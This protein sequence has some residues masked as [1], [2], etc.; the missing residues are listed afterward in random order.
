VSADLNAPVADAIA[1][2]RAS[3]R[4][5]RVDHEPDGQGGAFVR[6]H[7]LEIGRAFNPGTSWIGFQITFQFPFADIYPHYLRSDLTSADGKV[8][9]P[10]LHVNNSFALPS[11][12][13]PAVMLSRRS[14]HRDPE[15]ET[16]AVKLIKVLDWLRSQ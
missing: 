5:H 8:L 11:G 16:A 9:T 13:V 12:A 4:T 2:I 3:F 15:T 7:D 10:P 6:V 1:E 14:N